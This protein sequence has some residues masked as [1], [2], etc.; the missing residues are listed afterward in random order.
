MSAGGEKRSTLTIGVRSAKKGD[1]EQL[2][3]LMVRLKRL[4]AEFDPLLNVR[5]DV[6]Q[7]ARKILGANL[8]DSNYLIL[9]VEAKDRP[10]GGIVGVVRSLLRD[11]PFYTPVKE[12]VIL[13]IYLMPAYRRRG[14]GTYVLSETVRHLKSKG[15]DIVTA[16]FPSQNDIAVKFYARHGFRAV[17]SHHA[18]EV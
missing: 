16:E 7:Q 5:E 12:G 18:K 15:A 8:E 10:E 13:D 1:L 11:R 2:A 3:G 9:T 6:D 17:T 4:N 14:S